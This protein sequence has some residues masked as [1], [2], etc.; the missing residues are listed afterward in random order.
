MIQDYQKLYVAPSET[1]M[2]KLKLIPFAV[3]E[4]DLSV[5]VTTTISLAV[6][7]L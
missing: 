6:D 1:G 4:T 3:I 2:L 5:P 7:E